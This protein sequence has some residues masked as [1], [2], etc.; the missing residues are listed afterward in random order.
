MNQHLRQFARQLATWAEE[1]IIQGRTPFRRVDTFSTIHTTSGAHEIPLILWIN[2][3]SMMPGG[4]VLLP[5]D[6][7]E[8]E[9]ELG[10]YCADALGLQHFVT[11]EKN[12]VR[13]WQINT[14][15]VSVAQTFPL[16]NPEHPETF[17]FVLEDLLDALKLTAVLGSVPVHELSASY[18]HNLCQITLQQTLPPMIEAYR[19]QRAEGIDDPTE[20][21]DSL[22]EQANRQILLQLLALLW[23]EKMPEKILPEKMERALELCIPLLPG[24][25]PQVLTLEAITS[26]PSIPLESAVAFHHFLL[27]MRQLSWNKSPVQVTQCLL[28]LSKN[29]YPS[30]DDIQPEHSILLYPNAPSSNEKTELIL[31][32]SPSLLAMTALLNCL[33][34]QPE[35]KLFLGHLFKLNKQLLPSMMIHARLFNQRAVSSAERSAFTTQLRTSWPHRRFKIK[36]GQPIWIWEFIHLL[37]ICR[38]GQEFSIEFPPEG[39]QTAA[40]ELIWNLL[41]ENFRFRE[42]HRCKDSVRLICTREPATQ[43]AISVHLGN[44]TREILPEEQVHSFRNQLLLTMS[45]PRDIYQLLGHELIWP[46]DNESLYDD[47]VEALQLYRQSH[48]Y[49]WLQHLVKEEEFHS[50]KHEEGNDAVPVCIPQ[51]SHRLLKQLIDEKQTQAHDAFPQSIDQLL[52]V[53]LSCPAI[54]LIKPQE[55][56]QLPTEAFVKTHMTHQ[57]KESI[58]QDLTT[59]GIPNF[60]EQYLY[61][62]EQPDMQRYDLIPPVKI[63]SEVLGQFILED[64]QGQIIEGYGEE[65]KQALLICSHSGKQKVD[66]PQSREHIDKILAY[67]RKDLNA[68]Y[69]YLNNLCYSQIENSKVARKMINKVWKQLALPDPF[70]FKN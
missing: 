23:F 68:L 8:N 48:L 45:L 66:L 50:I 17:H 34:K 56:H 10:R 21:I 27:R 14:D 58:L 26:P 41:F 63:Q 20:D 49:R 2:R 7:L 25:L 22:A 57:L 38:T 16:K 59:F 70:W 12:Q 40:N 67:F 44:E 51:P 31:S 15:A 36:T 43:D 42:I 55:N 54:A 47:E 29:W 18:F 28:E 33:L 24:Q 52:S 65:L 69:E 11:W 32:D 9:L 39:L 35:K 30:S 53:V 37:G 64:A 1:I 4:F 61:F 19:S 6:K 60:P 46:E 13:I 62:L 3:Q 5:N